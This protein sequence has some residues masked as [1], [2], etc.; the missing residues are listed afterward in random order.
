VLKAPL[1]PNQ[2]INQPAVTLLNVSDAVLSFGATTH[3][4]TVVAASEFFLCLLTA[5]LADRPLLI[6]CPSHHSR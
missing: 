5:C 4:G 6:G 2:P 1:N 3:F